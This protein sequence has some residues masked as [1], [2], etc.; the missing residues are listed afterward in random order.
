MNN[1]KSKN[2][3]AKK[4]V[5]IDEGCD[6]RQIAQIMT[7]AGYPMNH[8]TAR[9]QLMLA[10]ENLLSDMSRQV[11]IKVEKKHIIDMLHNQEVH[12]S[13]ADVLQLAYTEL[14]TEGKLQ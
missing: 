8:A 4:Y 3:N 7:Q 6:F 14:K 10:M 13:L 5:I 9:N 11:G 1:G 2:A 12:N